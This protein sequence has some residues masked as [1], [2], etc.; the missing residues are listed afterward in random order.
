MHVRRR[1]RKRWVRKEERKKG[2][3]EGSTT[4]TNRQTDRRPDRHKYMMV[5][6]WWYKEKDNDRNIDGK[7]S[8]KERG[9]E[10]DDDDDDDDDAVWEHT[11]NVPSLMQPPLQRNSPAL[12]VE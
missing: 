1:G 3:K 10:R 9:R 4:V 7:N 5:R 11:H 2:R 12:E 6:Y 8:L